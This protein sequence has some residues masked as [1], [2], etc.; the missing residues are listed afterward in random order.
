[1][2]ARMAEKTVRIRPGRTTGTKPVKVSV[3][4]LTA[5]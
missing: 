1:M 4:V 3:L 2:T 5:P